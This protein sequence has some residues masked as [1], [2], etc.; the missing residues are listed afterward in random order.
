VSL[1]SRDELLVETRATAIWTD[2]RVRSA[3]IDPVV[4]HYTGQ[5]ELAAAMQEGLEA[6]EA[7]DVATAT[8]RLGRAVQLA[9]QT[10]HRDSA[11]LL[12][13]LVDVADARTG[14]VRLREDVSGVDAEMA[15][16]RSVR[17]VQVACG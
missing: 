16:V 15:N 14:A 7:G 10:G 12:E 3:R 2:D 4:A 13:R 9:E 8:T 6:R 11:A 1:V 17:T 5:A